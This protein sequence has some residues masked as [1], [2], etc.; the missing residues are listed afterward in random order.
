MKS[1]WIEL[2][3]CKGNQTP[4]W[5]LVAEYLSSE[6]GGMIIS[7]ADVDRIDTFCLPLS[8]HIIAILKTRGVTMEHL[9]S[10][11]KSQCRNRNDLL[12][13]IRNLKGKLEKDNPSL[14]EIRDV[15]LD[16]LKVCLTNKYHGDDWEVIFR[17][18]CIS[19]GD[20]HIFEINL[21]IK[22]LENIKQKQMQVE[23]SPCKVLFDLMYK[24]KPD[25]SLLYIYEA[26]NFV[27]QRSAAKLFIKN[28]ET[29]LHLKRPKENS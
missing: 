23:A 25:L 20:G 24:G 11:I 13:C 7:S 17:E 14:T 6:E 12:M 29:L 18:V 10:A 5:K 8:D 3:S 9:E 28:I 19:T 16:D 26:L 27:E 22:E 15:Q 1:L 2:E 21:I 4:G